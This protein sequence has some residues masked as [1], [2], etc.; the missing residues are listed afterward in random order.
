M[1]QKLSKL[2]P[3]YLQ[4]DCNLQLTSEEDKICYPNSDGS[5]L[6]CKNCSLEHKEVCIG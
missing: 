4:K 1:C 6:Y 5:R 2:S 3:I